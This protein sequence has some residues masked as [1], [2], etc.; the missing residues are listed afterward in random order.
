MK[1]ILP[2]AA[3]LMAFL[4]CN[5]QTAT[6]AADS[7]VLANVNG[8]RITEAM[9]ESTVHAGIQDPAKAETFLHDPSLQP[10]RAQ[11]VHQLARQ[12]AIEQAAAKAGIERDPSVEMNLAQARA[13]I[14]ASVLASRAAGNATPTE[15]QLQA[16]YDELV[17]ARKAAGQAQG[18]PPFEQVKA[19]PQFVEAW[20]KQQFQKASEAFQKD[21]RAQVPVTYAD[22]FQTP[23]AA[24]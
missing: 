24:Y 3:A 17:A 8:T 6:T 14:Y 18:L 2:L 13:D 21:L 15:A 16:F 20:Q 1:R 4:G 11:L 22:G 7:P 5:H 23:E 10:Q 12:A 9:L 19:L